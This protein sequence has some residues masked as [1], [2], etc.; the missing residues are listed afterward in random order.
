MPSYEYA[1][2]F[3]DTIHSNPDTYNVDHIEEPSAIADCIAMELPGKHFV[4]RCE[5][6][7]VTFDFVE[8]LTQEEQDTITSELA[9]HKAVDDWP[10]A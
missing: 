6:A 9:A 4:V 5:G 7:T 2:E 8:T 10:P 1:R 3:G